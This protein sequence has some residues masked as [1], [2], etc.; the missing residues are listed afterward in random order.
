MKMS[1]KKEKGN[2]TV[3][4]NWPNSWKTHNLPKTHRRIRISKCL[5]ESSKNWLS[6]PI[7]CPTEWTQGHMVSAVSS[8]IKGQRTLIACQIFRK[9][10]VETP[11]LSTWEPVTPVGSHKAS[12]VTSSTS[13]HNQ[14][15]PQRR[16]LCSVGRDFYYH[17]S[18]GREPD[19]VKV[20]PLGTTFLQCFKSFTLL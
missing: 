10:N 6:Y 3:E 18:T 20:Q 17:D 5:Q 11:I 1:E 15:P 16:M 14:P 13:F 2:W 19:W 12:I 7:C 8:P 4:M 9:V